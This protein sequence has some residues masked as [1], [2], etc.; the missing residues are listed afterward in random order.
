MTTLGKEKFITDNKGK[1]EAVVLDI[2]LY[3]EIL[4]NLEDLRLLAERKDEA[5]S[6]LQEVEE[7]L[8]ARGL[9]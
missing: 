7:R 2:K 8:K 5:T 3:Q 4:E 6:S 9:L 1:K